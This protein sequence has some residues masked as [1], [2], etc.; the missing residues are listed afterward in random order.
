MGVA[1]EPVLAAEVQGQGAAAEDGWQDAGLACQ[2]AGVAG[3]VVVAGVGSCGTDRGVARHAGHL[4]EGCRAA[5]AERLLQGHGDYDGCG[6]FAG[7][8]VGGE[9]FEEVGEGAATF[10]V[11]P[12]PVPVVIAEGVCS[13]GSACVGVLAVEVG[14]WGVD[15]GVVVIAAWGRHGVQDLPEDVGGPGR[16]REVAGRGSIAAVVQ[17]DPCPFVGAA[18]LIGQNRFLVL[19]DLG[20]WPPRGGESPRGRRAE[21]GRVEM[22][23]VAHEGV[24]DE[25]PLTRGQVRRQCR[26]C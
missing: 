2:S 11:P 1:E 21:P 9:V 8:G 17:G 24:L 3:G 10:L 4:G 18:L 23:R 22:G 15:L 26:H 19:G 13:T 14:W 7:Q 16:H 20:R 25:G 5:G 6:D 12:E